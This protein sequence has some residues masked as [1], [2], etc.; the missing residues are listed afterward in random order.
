MWGLERSFLL[1]ECSFFHDFGGRQSGYTS[2]H[3]FKERG[4]TELMMA[5]SWGVAVGISLRLTRARRGG[6]K[7]L[8]R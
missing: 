3:F 2:S 6:Q 5:K 7:F 4:K 8:T 1:R